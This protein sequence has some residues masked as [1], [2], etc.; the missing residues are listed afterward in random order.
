LIGTLDEKGFEAGVA[1]RSE[2]DQCYAYFIG[3]W[4]AAVK[5]KHGI[6]KRYYERLSDVGAV[7]CRVELELAKKL[8]D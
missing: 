6:A 3:T 8:R 2:H 7:N 5:K 4:F 1:G